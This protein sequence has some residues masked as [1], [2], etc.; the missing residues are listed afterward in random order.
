MPVQR[1]ERNGEQG[2]QYGN[3]GKCYLASE[4]GSDDKAKQKAYLQGAAIEQGGPLHKMAEI[5]VPILKKGVF[6]QMPIQDLTA[7][8]RDT[9]TAMPYLLEAQQSGKYRGTKNERFNRE[10]VPPFIHLKHAPQ[11]IALQKMQEWAAGVTMEPE[12]RLYNGE[13]WSFIKFRNVDPELAKLLAEGFPYRSAELLPNFENPDTGEIYPVVLRSV[14]FLGANTGPAVP[15]QPGYS[16]KL[17]Q[18]EMGVQTVHCGVPPDINQ[19]QKET[20]M[21]EQH[22]D[23]SVVTLAQEPLQVAALEQRLQALED[24]RQALKGVVNEM[25]A[26]ND[27]LLSEVHK[28]QHMAKANQTEAYCLKLEKDYALTPAAIAAIRPLVNAEEGIVKLSEEAEDMPIDQAVLQVLETVLKL[29]KEK[30]ALFVPE[31]VTLPTGK[32]TEHTP[33]PAEQREAGILKLQE[34]AKANGHELSYADARMQW[35]ATSNDILKSFRMV[36]QE[37]EE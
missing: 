7:I 25:K 13:E 11:E 15:Q 31:P 20:H 22:Q 4:E 34:A 2:W 29:A 12:S 33:T 3:T 35:A 8:A 27:S 18:E 14:A 19:Q 32:Q 23:A 36:G 28:F 24:E 1:C 16:V 21:A 10:P 9:M 17:A 6:N 30:D 5:D 26:T 37:G